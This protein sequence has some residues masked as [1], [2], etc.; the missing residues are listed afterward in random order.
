MFEIV[1]LYL[2]NLDTVV[3]ELE[4]ILSS[5]AIDNTV[6][7]LVCNFGQSELLV[8][9]VC[10]SHARGFDISN[11]IVFSTDQETHDLAQGLGL[12]SYFDHRVRAHI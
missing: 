10:S 2:K 5:I 11:V 8:N 6:I 1:G 9:F 3:E 12:A 7:V 4:P